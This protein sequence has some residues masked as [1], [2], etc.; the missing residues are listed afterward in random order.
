MVAERF[1]SPFAFME[2]MVETRKNKRRDLTGTAL[3]G[4][5]ERKTW[6]LGPMVPSPGFGNVRG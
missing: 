3:K 5:K 1:N 4:K 2:A 6:E